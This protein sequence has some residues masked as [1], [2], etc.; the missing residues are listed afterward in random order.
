MAIGAMQCFKENGFSIPDDISIIGFDDVT[1][2][3]YT[4]PKLSSMSVPKVELGIQATRMIIDILTNQNNGV[5][6]V[7]FPV[8]VIARESVA[9]I[10][11]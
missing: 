8:K 3:L 11:S 1:A 9:K 6:E 2:D 10:N 5:K 4:K 7:L